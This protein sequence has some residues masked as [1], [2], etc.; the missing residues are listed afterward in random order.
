M[1]KDPSRN[2]RP[3]LAFVS[4]DRW[5]ADRPKSS[6]DNAWDV[7]P[8][9][10]VEV[11]S[12]YDRA[13]EQLKKVLEYFEAG[14]R[15]VWVVFPEW[16]VIHVYESPTQIRVLTEADTLDGG[17]VL[18]GFQLPLDRLFDP[19]VPVDDGGDE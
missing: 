11:I 19:V 7:V 10:A 3:D 12:P 1:K 14:V 9:L 16:R 4:S 15:L 17:P 2:R 8:D 13:N 6:R 18:P 5:P